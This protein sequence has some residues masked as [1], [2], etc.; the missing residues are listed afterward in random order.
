[1]RLAAVLASALL[2]GGCFVE[3][4]ND[5][6]PAPGTDAAPRLTEPGQCRF[7]A[8]TGCFQ[9]SIPAAPE[10]AVEGYKFMDA[11]DLAQNFAKLIE[12]E[13]V[14]GDDVVSAETDLRL[15]TQV[16][17]DNFSSG[18]QVFLRGAE[19]AKS[20]ESLVGGNFLVNKL[21]EDT[22]RVRVQKQI[23]FELNRKVTRQTSAEVEP[24]TEESTRIFCA[25]LYSDAAADVRAGERTRHVFSD[26]KLFVSNAECG[27]ESSQTALRL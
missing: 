23:K 12:V 9:G 17:N 13:P 10:L 20:A 18:F 8:T 22:Y 2:V 3:D 24:T 25:T 1:M 16:D 14:A 6:V 27:Q 26:Y 4:V 21:V 15:L 11:N 19:G 5:R 7:T